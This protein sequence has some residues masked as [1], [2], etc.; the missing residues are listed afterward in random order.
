MIYTIFPDLF[1]NIQNSEDSIYI[2]DLINVFG[3]ST[4]PFRIAKDKKGIVID[5]YASIQS[6]Y[7]IFFIEFL[8]MLNR[9]PSG[10][11]IIDVDIESIG[12]EETQFLK[13]CKET[14]GTNKMIVY[15]KQNIIKYTIVENKVEFEEK[16][17]LLLDRDEA[18]MVLNHR[19]AGDTYYIS[20]SQAAFS[21]S[22]I[23]N[24]KN[25]K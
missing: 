18:R 17:I 22:N 23:S 1:R 21:N 20:D 8:E 2:R 13:L 10:Y 7:R 19:N 25:E 15:S 9:Y 3:I 4:N 11:E 16:L 12:C 6:K 24:S 5:V 14:K